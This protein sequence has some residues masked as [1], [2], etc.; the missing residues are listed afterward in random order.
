MMHIDACSIIDTDF[1][2]CAHMIEGSGPDDGHYAI[3]YL[4]IVAGKARR[5]FVDYPDKRTRDAA[6][7][8]L[9]LRVGRDLAEHEED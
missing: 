1:I 6:F 3:A 5:M 8:S 2:A 9:C 4:L 7:E